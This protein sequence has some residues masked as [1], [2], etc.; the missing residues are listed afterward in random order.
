MLI[1]ISRLFQTNTQTKPSTPILQ[2]EKLGYQHIKARPQTVR[3][4]WQKV[5]GLT[6]SK[7]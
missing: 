4:L 7:A 5:H 2:L 6:T 3:S 1:K